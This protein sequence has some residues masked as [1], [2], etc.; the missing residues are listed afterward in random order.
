M[1]NAHGEWR[2]QLWTSTAYVGAVVAVNVGFSQSPDLDWF[3]SFVVGGV[4]V[5]RDAVQRHWGHGVLGLMLMAAVLSY[6]LANPAVALASATAFLIS[7]TV[8]WIVYTTTHRP[9]AQRVWRSVLA[10]A[11]LDTAT[12]LHLAQIWSWSLFAIGVAS[13]VAAGGVIALALRRRS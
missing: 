12:F 6:Q 11:P 1:N 8:D 2:A 13:K 9:F 7:E 10:S 3:W 5:L 4:L